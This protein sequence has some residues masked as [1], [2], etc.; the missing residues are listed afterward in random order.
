MAAIRYTDYDAIRTGLR[1]LSAWAAQRELPVY[2]P[3]K[4]ACGLGGGLW[5]VVLAIIEQ[6]CP[7]AII[8]KPTQ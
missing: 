6:E 4:I 1:K 2:L 7:S 3:W 5:E 8:C